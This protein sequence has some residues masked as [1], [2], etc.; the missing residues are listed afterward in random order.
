MFY[1]HRLSLRSLFL[2]W[3]DALAIMLSAALANTLVINLAGGNG[4]FTFV[5]RLPTSIMATLIFLLTFFAGGMYDPQVLANRK[6][7]FI[8]T[9]C[10]V[11]IGLALITLA[12]YWKFKLHFGRGIMLVYVPSIIASTYAIRFAYHIVVG[13]GFFAKP[14][15]LVGEGDEIRTISNLLAEHGANSYKVFGVVTT[16]STEHHEEFLNGV[17]VIGNFNRLRE[18]V[19]AYDIENIIVATSLTKEDDLLRELRPLRYDGVVILDFVSLHEQLARSIPLD[20]I[21]DE[22]LLHAA[23]NSRHIHIRKLKR[24][25]D[26]CVAAFSL[27]LMLPICVLAAVAIKV[28]SKGP[29]FYRQVRMGLNGE[30]FKVIK[31]RTMYTDAERDGAVWAERY[32]ARITRIGHFL[33]TSRI[34][35]IPQLVNVLRGQMSLVGP[36]PERPEFIETLSGSI[37]FYEERLLIPPGITGWAQI[38]YPYAASVAAARAKLQYDLYYIK[39]TS[40]LM[41]V[42]ILIR[43]FKTIIVGMRHSEE[44]LPDRGSDNN[45]TVLGASDETT[46]KTDDVHS[47]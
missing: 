44:A 15:L 41:D 10:C 5:D 3:M 25:M 19:G 9:N 12:F 20:H 43:T 4:W 27:F 40:L 35:E 32:D 8:I 33:R 22:W 39:H 18:Y 24:I 37:P 16:A 21:D 1:R 7:T 23:M 47:A 42:S 30:Y 28:T 34:D 2:V 36:R 29:V 17:P 13:A 38:R 6:K 26:F 14:T 46:S 11:F 45:L 31:F